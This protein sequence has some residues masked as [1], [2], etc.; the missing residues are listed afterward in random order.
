M[1]ACRLPMS[2]LWWG[3]RDLPPMDG[4]GLYSGSIVELLALI[5]RQV[6]GEWLLKTGG[7]ARVSALSLSF[8]EAEIVIAGVSRASSRLRRGS[9][10]GADAPL[11][12]NFRRVIR[13]QVVTI[14]A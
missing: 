4:I 13:H 3:G 7:R 11:P 1:L 2:M 14:T 9:G 8:P 12:R 6:V 10:R 5:V